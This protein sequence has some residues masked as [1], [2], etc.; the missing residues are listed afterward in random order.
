MVS[1]PVLIL[2]KIE[3]SRLPMQTHKTGNK[4]L[5]A[6]AA[7]TGFAEG[8]VE[9]EGVAHRSVDCAVEDVS[10]GFAL[11]KCRLV[12]ALI[13]DSGQILTGGERVSKTKRT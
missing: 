9:E 4:K 5:G 8:L 10:E 6:F 11:E 13:S 2:D 1:A 12:T 3:M 7:S